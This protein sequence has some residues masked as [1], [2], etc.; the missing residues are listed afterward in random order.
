MSE[1]DLREQIGVLRGELESLTAK[2]RQS[3][4]DARSEIDALRIEIEVLHRFL[5]EAHPQFASA[6]DRLHEAV[7]CTVDP[8]FSSRPARA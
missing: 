2:Q 4:L 8:E 1:R 3:Q 6:Y 7:L 5:K